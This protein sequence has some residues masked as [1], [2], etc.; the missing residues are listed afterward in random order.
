VRRRP[1]LDGPLLLLVLGSTLLISTHLRKVDRYWFQVTPWIL[2][3]ATVALVEIGR[4]VAV[5]R[6]YLV[7]VAVLLPLIAIVIAHL[8]VLPGKVGDARDFNAA[9]GV[10]S[11]P[12]NPKV[13]PIFDAVEKFTPPDAVIAYYRARTMTLLTDRRSFQTTKLDRIEQNADY[14]AQRRGS[15]YWQPTLGLGDARLAGFVE[16][17]SDAN[18]VLWRTPGPDEG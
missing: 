16:V 5:R 1:A 7:R 18:W 13:A 11:G 4:T 3:F 2:Y 6:R 12:T 9:G 10:Q 14:F 17:W 15:T 8:V